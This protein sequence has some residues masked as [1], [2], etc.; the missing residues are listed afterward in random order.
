MTVERRD[1]PTP[2]GGAYSLVAY[3]RSVDDLRVVDKDQAGAVVITEYAADDSWIGE[4][5]ASISA[6]EPSTAP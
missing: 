4:V 6:P 2:N 1:E 3:V 5:V